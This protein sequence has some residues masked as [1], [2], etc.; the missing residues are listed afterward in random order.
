[1]STKIEWAT[2]PKKPFRNVIGRCDEKYVSKAK[3]T[4]KTFWIKTWNVGSVLNKK[5]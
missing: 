3:A 2:E 4:K 1:M 5:K